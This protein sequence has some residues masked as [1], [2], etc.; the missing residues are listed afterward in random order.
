MLHLLQV[1]IQL[2]FFIVK[3]SKCVHVLQRNLICF[4]NILTIVGCDF[5][6]THMSMDMNP[7]HIWDTDGIR[8]H[9]I[10]SDLD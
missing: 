7:S 6:V 8:T 1:N 9:L 10:V 3:T 2:V 5:V 4:E